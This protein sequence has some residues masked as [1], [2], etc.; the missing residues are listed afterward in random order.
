MASPGKAAVREAIQV[1][2]DVPRLNPSNVGHSLLCQILEVDIEVM[3]VSL[4]GLPRKAALG[5]QVADEQI[6]QAFHGSRVAKHNAAASN[7]R[8]E[9]K[10]SRQIRIEPLNRMRY[11]FRMHLPRRS[12]PLRGWILILIARLTALRFARNLMLKKL[13]RDALINRLPQVKL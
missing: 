8:L 4:H 7:R 11:P 5:A 1:V 10:R 9:P 3:R 2:A 13:R 12:P 6:E